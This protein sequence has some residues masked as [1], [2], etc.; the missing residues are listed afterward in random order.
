MGGVQEYEVRGAG[1]DD[2]LRGILALQSANLSG[3]L[4]EEERRAQGFV[5]LRH[6]LDLLREMNT[7]WGHAIATPAGSAEVVAYA[8]VM[9]PGFR[10]R[11]A[12]LEPMFER[13]DGL[14]Y[15]GGPMAAQRWYVMGQL[16]VAR[17]HRGRGLVERLYAD[18]RAR[19]SGEFDVMI[20][21][22][23][24]ANSRSVRV[25]ERAGFEVV[26]EYRAAS[27][28]EWVVVALDLARGG[29]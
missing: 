8:L 21:E 4:S 29:A 2:E 24:R 19:L 23:N 22:V 9:L 13:I 3:V 28:S 16:C 18:H 11:V 15:R 5:T 25:H 17:A 10:G 1:S 14:T 20:T 27:G 26:D 7:P 6:D 12:L